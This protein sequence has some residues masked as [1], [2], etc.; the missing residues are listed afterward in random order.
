MKI[1]ELIS[2][3]KIENRVRELAEVI[4]E[5]FKGTDP[6]FI[7]VLNGGFMFTTDLLK[8][9]P[10]PIQVE[11]I[12]ASSYLNNTYSSGNVDLTETSFEVKDRDIII[13]ED[14][15]DTGRTLNKIKGYLKEK[16]A[17]NIY[18]VVLLDKPARRVEEFKPDYV[19]FEID[20]HFV[21]GYG[22]DYKQKGRNLPFIGIIE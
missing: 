7:S 22:I 21:A 17:K 8:N 18:S 1:K 14:I 12:K 6:L 5:D 3:E 10:Y 15:L 9:I 4:A 11:F 19:G 16:G 13:I 2:K 20:D